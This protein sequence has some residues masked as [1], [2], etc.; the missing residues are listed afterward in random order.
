MIRSGVLVFKQQLLFLI[1]PFPDRCLLVP[2][3]NFDLCSVFAYP[4]SFTPIRCGRKCMVSVGIV[5]GCC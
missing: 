5:G 1:A 4:F 2:F 3:Y